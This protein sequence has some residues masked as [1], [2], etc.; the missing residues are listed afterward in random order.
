MDNHKKNPVG[1]EQLKCKNI[2]FLLNG[3]VH[4]ALIPPGMTLLE[5]L[6]TTL[7]LFGT[8]STCNEGDCGSCTVLI[9]KRRGG[10]IVYQAVNSCLYPAVRI[11]NKHLITIEGIGRPD[12]LHPIQEALLDYHGTQCGYC[13]PGFVMA[14]LALL[15]NHPHPEKDDILKALEGNLCRCTGYDAIL[16]AAMHLRGKIT[17]ETALL[18]DEL[19]AVEDQ[20]GKMSNLMTDESRENLE[21]FGTVDYQQ[22]KSV[23][24][25]LTEL[26]KFANREDY[27][28]INGATDLLVQANVGRVFRPHLIDITEITDLNLIVREGKEIRIGPTATLA[29]IFRSSLIEQYFPMFRK[30]ISLIASEQIRNLATLSGNIGNASPVAD[31]PPVLMTLDAELELTSSA[32]QRRVKLADFYL[33]YKKTLLQVGEFI[34]GIIIPIPEEGYCYGDFQKAAKRRAVDISTVNSAITIRISEGR[35][36]EVRLAFGGVAPY[37]ALAKKTMTF[38]EGR[39]FSTDWF[40]EAAEVAVKEFTPI[41]DV[42]GREEYRQVLIRNQTMNFLNRCFEQYQNSLREEKR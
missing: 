13:T 37:P 22:P 30:T 28:I 24:E 7:N 6:H 21:L 15:I 25:L 31:T 32:G 39:E 33:D 38:M 12:K 14:L 27:G 20:I 9:G 8:K 17:G 1:S 11:H 42:R 36:R 29:E 19:L 34:S 26:G 4:N 16:Q 5:M 35:I 23:N 40:E 41:S 3:K 10:E 2:T 18:T